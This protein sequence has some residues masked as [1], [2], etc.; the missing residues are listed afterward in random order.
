[1]DKNRLSP[2]EAKKNLTELVEKIGDEHA[3]EVENKISEAIYEQI[4][5]EFG[6][7]LHHEMEYCNLCDSFECICC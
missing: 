3:R 1:M 2:W 5:F 7:T 4:Y 6:E